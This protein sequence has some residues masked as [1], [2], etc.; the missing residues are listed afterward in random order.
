[1]DI[2]AAATVFTDPRAY[3]DNERF[4]TATALLRRESP[5]HRVEHPRFNPFWAITKHEDVLAI[6]RGSDIWLNA[7]RPA[8]GPKAKDAE[9]ANIPIRSLVQMDAPDHPVYRHISADW[10][11][12]AGVRRLRDR[13]AE[14][15]KR[16][17]DHMA[18]LG[19]EC[20]FFV[21]VAAHY[22]LY[23][24]LSLLGLPED[25]FPRML[26]LTQELFG[27]ADEDLARSQDKQAQ[28]AV[29]MDFFIYFQG[30]IQDRRENPTDDLGS[31]IAN[32]MVHGEQMGELEA[33]GYYTLIATAGHD[34]TSSA[35]AGGLHALLE[36][37]DQWGRLAD[38]PALVAPGVDEMIRWVSPVKQFMR[39]ATEDTVVRG[40]PI[41]AG[42]SVLLSYPS[43]NRD[44]DVFD[45]PN[46]FDVGRSPNRHVAFGFGAHYCLG[47]HL[48]RLEGQAL[49]AEL[50]S[51]VRSI[52]L[53]GTPEYTETLFVGGPKRLPIR[54]T[55]A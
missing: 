44:E 6:A 13:I 20:D 3:A 1:M 41:A 16:Y 15:A 22:P 51:R 36:N 40:V 30:L 45:N 38:D 18:D 48:A 9:R 14:L 11:K 54:Y 7:P 50:V 24:I 29:L 12:P 42:E 31:V 39:T 26:K 21:D 43:A 17:V 23:V 53:A 52:E 32:A 4:H 28:M 35:L 27:A 10:F 8:L 34:T 33:A 19:G 2:A 49:Y 46:T 5:V 37:P 25:D 47:T 55:M